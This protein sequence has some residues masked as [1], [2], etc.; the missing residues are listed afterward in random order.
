MIMVRKCTSAYYR[1]L[2]VRNAPKIGYKNGVSE[3][4]PYVTKLKDAK[5]STKRQTYSLA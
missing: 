4:L 1:S 5:R 2:K 3:V